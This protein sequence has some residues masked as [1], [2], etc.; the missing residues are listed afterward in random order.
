MS[1]KC[2]LVVLAILVTSGLALAAGPAVNTEKSMDVAGWRSRL[3][4]EP[5]KTRETGFAVKKLDP[6]VWHLQESFEGTF[7]PAGWTTVDVAGP[8]FSWVQSGA[9]FHSGSY[10]ALID[11]DC[12]GGTAEDWLITPPI[13]IQADDSIYFW[14]D[15][16]DFGYPPDDTYLKISTTDSLPASFTTTLWHIWDGGGYVDGWAQ[17]AVDLSAYAGQTVYLAFQHTDICGDGIFIDD[18][19]VGHESPTLSHDLALNSIPVPA[20]VVSPGVALVPEVQ[21]NNPGLSPE[22][23]YWLYFQIDDGSKAVVYFDSLEV[24]S[25]DT[26]QSESLKQYTFGSFIPESLTQYTATAWV[27]LAG[28]SYNANDTLSKGFRSYDRDMGTTAI[29]VPAG[30]YVNPDSTISPTATFHNYAAMTADFEAYFQIDSAGTPVYQQNLSIAGLAPGADTTVAFAPWP[31]PHSITNYQA[32]AYAVIGLDLDPGNDTMTR[33][34]STAPVWYYVSNVPD[35][36]GLYT[37]WSYCGTCVSNNLVWM[38]GGRR[39]AAWTVLNNVGTYDPA[40]DTWDDT[41]PVLNQARVY[42]TAAANDSYIF[43]LGGRDGAG[44]VCYDNMERLDSPSGSAWSVMTPMPAARVFGSAVADGQYVY[45]TGGTSD[46][47]GS[48]PTTTLW[49]YDI[50]GDTVGGTPW[51][52]TLA[53]LPAALAQH[54]AVLLDGK[55]YIPGNETVL[56]TYI[57]DIAT[58]AWDSLSNGAMPGATQYQAVEVHGRIWRIGGIAGGVS[59]NQVYELDTLTGVWTDILKPMQQTRINFGCGRVCSG[60]VDLVVALGGVAFPG[61]TPTMTSEAIDVAW[62]GVEGKPETAVPAGSYALQPNSPNPFRN[63]TSICFN[64]TSGGWVKMEIYN[65]VGQKIKTLID[66]NYGAGQHTVKWNGRNEAGQKVSN[67]VYMYRMTS[68]NFQATKK[69]LFVK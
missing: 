51:D 29:N 24:V 15:T 19:S 26:I 37:R 67:G 16:Y 11:Y 53:Q 12:F 21:V 69:L 65:I 14:M 40:T 56:L 62:M 60:G 55:I 13:T 36:G 27:A 66:G 63:E 33:D 61:F 18:V 7:P 23:D 32:V 46:A 35:N 43:A 6:K 17:Y 45:Y 22:S 44:A 30:G 64:L 58:D 9:S 57:Y 2:L 3:R 68:G 28:D 39:D 59:T 20:S 25:P 8:S 1:K 5:L 54:S 38:V 31:A 34:F 42:L 41:K 10:S 4:T 48:V 52:T 50:V 49:R 47:G